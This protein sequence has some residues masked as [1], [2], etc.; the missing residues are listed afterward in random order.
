MPH[1]HRAEH[2]TAPSE[3]KDGSSPCKRVLLIDDNE[4]YCKTLAEILRH[5][6]YQVEH[7]TDT[8]RGLELISAHC[9]DIAI[10]DYYMR[11]MSGIDLLKRIKAKNPGT[12]VFIVTGKPFIETA[13]KN[14]MVSH[15]VE[16]IVTK[17]SSITVMLD[18]LR[19]DR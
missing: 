19:G 12:R 16:G 1:R 18:K 8:S 3:K 14:D 13:I 2:N 9:F 7:T 15:L 4:D 11:G 10:L 17:A 5:E 6:G